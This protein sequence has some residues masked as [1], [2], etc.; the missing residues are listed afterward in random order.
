MG[1]VRRGGDEGG[2][3]FYLKTSYVGEVLKKKG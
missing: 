1:D 3:S 2:G